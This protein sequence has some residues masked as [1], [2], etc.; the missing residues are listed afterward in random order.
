MGKVR[1]REEEKLKK[2]EYRD[3]FDEIQTNV[4][5]EKRN[6]GAPTDQL[7]GENNVGFRQQDDLGTTKFDTKVI[8]GIDFFQEQDMGQAERLLGDVIAETRAQEQTKGEKLLH[9]LG[10]VGAKTGTEFMKGIGYIGGAIPAL[11]HQDIELMTN[12]FWVE[13]FQEMEDASKEALPVYTR[14]EVEN[15]SLGRQI[16]SPEFWATDGADGLG[17]LLSAVLSGG[18][19]S[20]IA[21]T[22]K[23]GTGLAKMAGKGGK[24]AGKIDNGIITGTQTFLESAAETKGMVDGLKASWENKKQEDGTYLSDDGTTY[25]QEEVDQM[26]GGAGVETM[27]M[28]ALFLW[29][30]NA[31]QTKYL[32]GKGDD[33]ADMLKGVPKGTVK[34]MQEGLKTIKPWKSFA[35]AGLKSASAEA[36]QELSQFAIENYETK[37]G[38]GL[39]DKDFINGMVDGFVEGLTTIEGHKSMFLGA[40]LGIGP[41]A[42]GGYKESKAKKKQAGS[43]LDLMG[44]SS[45]KFMDEISAV[46]QKN[47]DGTI[48]LDP[49]TKK[50]IVDNVKFFELMESQS[51]GLMSSKLYQEAKLNKDVASAKF[52]L[53]EM[54]IRNIYP[55][56][57]TAGGI[58]LWKEHTG[59]MS[60]VLENDATDLGFD[61]V[62]D[63]TKFLEETA[64]KAKKEFRKVKDLGPAFFGINNKKLLEGKDNE[65]TANQKLQQFIGNIEYNAVRLATLQDNFRSELAEAQKEVGELERAI[66]RDED[67]EVT[68]RDAMLEP[69]IKS[70][71][72]K[73]DVLKGIITQNGETYTKLF[74]QA[75][76]QKAFDGLYEEQESLE[77]NIKEDQMQTVSDQSFEDTFY[78]NLRD[79]GYK[80]ENGENGES[81]DFGNKAIV[82]K[83]DNG[84][85]FRVEKQFNR[86]TQQS[87]Y[88]LK[89]VDTGEAIPMSVEAM[90]ELGLDKA[91]NILTRGEYAKFLDAQRVVERNKT[92]M[93]YLKELIG[94]HNKTNRNL[95]YNK[96]QLVEELNKYSEELDFW[97]EN[98]NFDD[99]DVA[100][101][102]TRLQNKIE[103]INVQIEE[104]EAKKKSLGQTLT[105][106][107]QYRTE[108]QEVIDSDIQTEFNFRSK[109]KELENKLL[110][111]E[112]ELEEELLEESIEVVDEWLESLYVI[113]DKMQDIVNDMYSVMRAENKVLF[114]EKDWEKL[115]DNDRYLLSTYRT[116]LKKL[117]AVKKEIKD[118]QRELTKLNTNKN[119]LV[120]YEK[121]NINLETL[122]LRNR[123]SI[124]QAKNRQ[125]IQTLSR[126]QDM[127]SPTSPVE[128][129][130]KEDVQENSAKK[131][132]PWST[133]TAV[134]DINKKDA[135]GNFVLSKN[136]Q[137]A[138]RWSKVMAKIPLSKLGD[139]SVRFVDNEQLRAL[140]GENPPVATEDALYAVLYQGNEEYTDE[141][142]VIYTGVANPDTY[143]GNGY[144]SIDV[145]RL[146]EYK[147]FLNRPITE[148]NPATFEDTEYTSVTQLKEVIIKSVA[149]S[150]T[151]WRK[152]I[153]DRALMGEVMYSGIS[154]IS[155]GFARRGT[156]KHKPKDVLEIESLEIPDK[157]QITKENG[158]VVDA[159]AGM[160][161]AKLKNGQVEKLKNH[162]I[163]EMPDAAQA[164]YVNKILRFM[165]LFNEMPNQNFKSQFNFKGTSSKIPLVSNSGKTGILNQ[166]INW[167]YYAEDDFSISVHPITKEGKVTE[168]LELVIRNQGVPFKMPL[169]ML[170]DEKG[171]NRTFGDPEIQVVVDFLKTK[172]MNVNKKDLNN[173][174]LKSFWLPTG[175]E[176]ANPRTAP[177]I[178]YKKYDSYND[179]VLDNALYTDVQEY[180]E[181]TDEIPTFVNQY[182]SFDE[183]ITP[184]LPEIVQD[185]AVSDA[186]SDATT[187]A[188]TQQETV[189]EGVE[190]AD[191]F[192]LVDV[193]NGT[194]VRDSTGEVVKP[195]SAGWK[196][197]MKKALKTATPVTNLVT[198]SLTDLGANA[199]GTTFN[200]VMKKQVAVKD[201]PDNVD[202]KD[203]KKCP[204]AP[205]GSKKTTKKF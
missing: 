58:E 195:N 50:P 181:S 56:L 88:F 123:I 44:K 166:M 196:A 110:N 138:A 167:G 89:N 62:E 81:N 164:S 85:V 154:D 66:P 76:Q 139:Y 46:Y 14:D 98:R 106:L 140:T 93:T 21:K 63:Y 26:I 77:K 53:S 203:K 125:S 114:E 113:R 38:K 28:N 175:W 145:M 159:E 17:F 84:V 69:F 135:D 22:L 96:T 32:F 47:E 19:T 11:I 67:G 75:E 148:E 121:L 74:D 97:K 7:V 2:Q 40:V 146:P 119:L 186:P 128:Q 60:E 90:I 152:D 72:K 141:T 133:I 49:K 115:D 16:W 109:L 52:A 147:P 116:E 187:D 87:E 169:S 30:P 12:N 4:A 176:K 156:E 105:T 190:Y 86:D 157:N 173:T 111:G 10:R 3:L 8:P 184:A 188:V 198:D 149:D 204:M 153:S 158:A 43:L 151:E 42:V 34:E 205:K 168:E 29:G 54:T 65:T 70:L 174:K 124:N 83:D 194:V 100:K 171:R 182:I 144:S 9:G 41:G 126:N 64:T 183:S 199:G 179:Y 165:Q 5:T 178:T 18:V 25:T 120:K 13:T 95:N 177:V 170:K 189:E 127:R 192:Y 162:T 132:T 160:V 117:N 193:A 31:L 185:D 39:Q 48:S 6:Q 45:Q 131:H 94:N 33:M 104:L 137:Q 134:F 59:Q 80:L 129:T 180:D 51:Q 155:K 15:G 37:K 107:R 61:T 172:Y 108:L 92:M 82:L 161:Y 191:D 136:Y 36:F 91:E 101:E 200:S 73:I 130:N 1:S 202:P 57:Q 68:H 99:S 79:K 55:Y 23:I 118:L 112:Y 102:I 163:G 20:G 122:R 143:F 24:V 103:E 71:N 142:G 78:K 35:S 150:Y 27:A 197:V 201:T